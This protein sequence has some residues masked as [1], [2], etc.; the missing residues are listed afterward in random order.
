MIAWHI[1]RHLEKPDE[2]RLVMNKISVNHEGRAF[3][4][5]ALR[6][7]VAQSK[8]IDPNQLKDSF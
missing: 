3:N 2:V 6:S 1:H 4:E 8:W 7:Y 5:D